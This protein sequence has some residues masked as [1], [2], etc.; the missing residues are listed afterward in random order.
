[1]STITSNTNEDNG[2]EISR[3]SAD[4][5]NVASLEEV[6]HVKEDTLVKSLSEEEIREAEEELI[7]EFEAKQRRNSIIRSPVGT[8][9]GSVE[10]VL[11]SEDEL[12]SNR[13][14]KKKRR[15]IESPQLENCT[16]ETMERLRKV[17]KELVNFNNENKNVHKTV[18]K[19]SKTIYDITRERKGGEVCR[20]L[21]DRYGKDQE[22]TEIETQLEEIKQKMAQM[23]EEYNNRITEQEKIIAELKMTAT[24]NLCQK[25]KNG[26]NKEIDL[27]ETITETY[28]DFVRI[29]DERWTESS[30]RAT[31]ME[32][33]NTTKVWGD[34]LIIFWDQVEKNRSNR[35][36]EVIKSYPEVLETEKVTSQGGEYAE[37][38]QCITYRTAN[39]IRTKGRSIVTI[40][41]DSTLE[42]M[43]KERDMFDI[44][45]EIKRLSISEKR[46][47]LEIVLPQEESITKMRKMIEA[48]LKETNIKATLIAKTKWGGKNLTSHPLNRGEA[49]L[50][51]LG[52]TENQT[53][54][55]AETLK[56]IKSNI[57]DDML[58]KEIK[59]V[60][61]TAKGDLIVSTKEGSGKLTEKIQ[62]ILQ[63][64]NVRQLKAYRTK[65]LHLRYVEPSAE[66][67]E[68]RDAIVYTG[69][70]Q[71][72]DA[73]VIKS[74][75][76]DRT[77]NQTV[78]IQAEEKDA[79][80]LIQADRIRIGL[81]NCKIQE[82][83]V[84]THCYRCWAYDHKIKDCKGEDRS[85]KCRRC[86]GEG[87]FEKTCREEAQCPL[88]GK[89]GHKVGSGACDAFRNA[90]KVGRQKE[91]GEIVG[92]SLD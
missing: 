22:T 62:G 58:L 38:K 34:N 4:Q 5:Q 51:T 40:F 66:E 43:Q 68:I 6:K 88:C 70:I 90:L 82:R 20:Q 42:E 31:T 48:I 56:K 64:Q 86:A 25:C 47:N 1:M 37:I 19:L 9:S 36:K 27:S 81:G 73:L 15:A 80:R 50:V 63:G 12:P 49:I 83:V 52:K 74:R 29:K 23:E 11:I 8:P 45:T 91:S 46:Q 16:D 69:M 57:K 79:E 17:A 53:N 72:N 7:K 30:Y 10:S 33:E 92:T 18:K 67:A 84:V 71:T 13:P 35:C 44:L 21:T 78:T 41:Y 59:S 28:E 39:G 87:H 2:K 24:D 3:I 89:V 32:T 26:V 85:Q 76:P 60:R 77:G 55:Y 14:T 61:K 75:R 65:I 54:D